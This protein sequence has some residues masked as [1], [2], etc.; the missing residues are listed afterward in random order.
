MYVNTGQSPK[1]LY[2]RLAVSCRK[3][4][5]VLELGL[6]PTC[7]LPQLNIHK[8]FIPNQTKPSTAP[9]KFNQVLSNKVF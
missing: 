2:F 7:T 4:I 3:G 9:N 1:F 6:N 5:Y 8:S